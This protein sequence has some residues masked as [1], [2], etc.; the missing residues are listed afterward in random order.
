MEESGENVFSNN[1]GAMPSG[2]SPNISIPES[3]PEYDFPLDDVQQKI[4][5]ILENTSR[6]VFL[7]GRAGTGK[8]TFVQYLRR[9]SKKRIRIACPTAAAAVNLGAVTLHSLYRFPLSDFFIFEDLLAV[10]RKKLKSILSRTDMLVI[11]EVSMVR[12]DMLDAVDLLSREAR[13][14]HLQPFGGLQVLLVGDLAQLPPVIKQ[15]AYKVFNE[16]YGSRQPYFFHAYVYSEAD[17]QHAELEKVY[18]QNDIELLDKL[19]CLRENRNISEAVNYFNECG[20][21]DR[22]FLKT[23][24][25]LTPYRRIADALNARRLSEIKSPAVDY[26]CTATGTFETSQ[27]CPAPRILSLKPGALVIFN[28]NNPGCWINGTAGIV[29]MLAPD[30]IETEIISSGHKAIVRQEEWKSY[31]YDFDRLTG[32]VYEEETGSFVQFPLQLGYALTIHKAQGKTLDKA[33]IDMNHGAFAHGQLYVALSRTRH[34]EDIRIMGR[35]TEDDVITD[36]AVQEFL[37]RK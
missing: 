10:P 1:A 4:F 19:A 30:F 22:D 24:V 29:R 2:I 17:F 36:P 13:G 9:H 21:A 26:K 23:A 11:D 5:D 34:K 33:V 14:N 35:I 32:R 6:N 7:Q 27:E 20:P 31:R 3:L 37:R 15:N 18:R 28:R 16:K 25:T 12:P 8:T